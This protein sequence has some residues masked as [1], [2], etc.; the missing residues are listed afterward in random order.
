MFYAPTIN[1]YNSIIL[2]NLP[3]MWLPYEQTERVPTIGVDL[4]VQVQQ[5][6]YEYTI[7]Y[8]ASH[9]PYPISHK[10]NLFDPD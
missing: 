6:S 8:L 3:R 10:Q 2:S 9:R 7:T 1:Y 5:I 4:F